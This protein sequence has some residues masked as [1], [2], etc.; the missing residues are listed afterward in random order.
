MPRLAALLPLVLALAA[1]AGR[2][3]DLAELRRPFEYDAS[4][5]IDAKL[6][7]VRDEGGVK[8]FDL[9]YPSPFD[10][11][12][13]TGFLV[14]PAGPEPHAGIVFGHWGPGNRTEFLPEA[15]MYAEA[16][17]VS[18]LIDYPW[19]R[20]DPWRRSQGQGLKEA[21]KDRDSWRHAVMDLRRAFDTTPTCAL[22][23]RRTPRSRWRP[24]SR[25]TGPTTPSATSVRRRPSRCCS[26]SRGTS[27][28]SPRRT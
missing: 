16:G 14:E 26:S 21:E 17:A 7:L 19:V 4:K 25:S 23:A 22:C 10:G 28:R 3:D 6:T 18:V 12:L 24:T 8:T 9:T 15:V 5:P 27:G 1:G 2:A 13:V 20:P 11:G